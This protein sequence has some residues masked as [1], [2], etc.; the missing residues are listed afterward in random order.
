MLAGD[1]AAAAEDFRW[2]YETL[3]AM[4][5]IGRSNSLGEQL[6]G[7]L[8]AQGRCDDAERMAHSVLV[9]DPTACNARAVRAKTLARRGMLGEAEQACREAT[10]QARA[11]DH[12]WRVDALADV[13]E[14]LRLAGRQT[15]AAPRCWRRR[16][17]SMKHWAA[18]SSPASSEP[19]SRHSLPN[20]IHHE[21]SARR[22]P[23]SQP[24]LAHISRIGAALVLIGFHRMSV[25]IGGSARIAQVEG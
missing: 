7:A 21:A 22:A 8:Y 5:D 11:A 14:A 17:P 1:P 12:V 16:W 13:A 20:V 6:A 23:R 9:S 18:R 15:E 2:G 10:E 3:R 25:Q 4:G 24:L 19:G